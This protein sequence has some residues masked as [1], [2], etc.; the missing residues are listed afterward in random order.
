MATFNSHTVVRRHNR[1]SAS[2]KTLLEIIQVNNGSRYDPSLVSSVHIFPDNSNGDPSVYLDKVSGSTRYGLVAPSAEASAVF[3]FCNSGVAD[4][5][6]A[7]FDVTGYLGTAHESSG[8]YTSSTG[9]FGVVL[10]PDAISPSA[11]VGTSGTLTNRAS[12]A[13]KCIDVWTIKEIVSSAWKTVSHNF[14][15]FD[16]T[17]LSLTEPIVLETSN[18]LRQKYVNAASVVNLEIETEVV[19]LNKGLT[20]E[21]KNIFNQSVIQDAEVKIQWLGNDEAWSDTVADGAT[22]GFV[23]ADV[24]SDDTMIYSWTAGGSSARTGVYQV[25]V[26]YILLEETIYSDKF[27]LI[28]R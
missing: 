9:K 6:N 25:Q 27:K 3:I 16:D 15:L 18:K 13:D 17:Y 20:D 5:G 19:V 7:A 14:E 26:K 21:I 28:V 24:L 2:S 10:T 4:P 1:P 22:N 23:A 11:L 12:S 8:I